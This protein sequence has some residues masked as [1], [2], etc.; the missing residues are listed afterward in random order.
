MVKQWKCSGRE[1]KIEPLRKYVAMTEIPNLY[2]IPA[3]ECKP[4]K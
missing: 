4:P 3:T 2:S 1:I